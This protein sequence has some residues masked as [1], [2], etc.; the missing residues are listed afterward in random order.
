MKAAVFSAGIIEKQTERQN[1]FVVN[2]HKT[3]DKWSYDDIFTFFKCSESM[4]YYGTLKAISRSSIQKCERWRN[5]NYFRKSTLKG[6]TADCVRRKI[7]II[8]TV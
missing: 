7:K 4:K 1:F 3:S 5:E 2:V 6:L 8:R